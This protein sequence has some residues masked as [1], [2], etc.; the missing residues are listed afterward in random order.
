MVIR[1]GRAFVQSTVGP[2]W[3]PRHCAARAGEPG[4]PRARLNGAVISLALLIG[5]AALRTF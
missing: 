5:H 2:R 3:I 4:A 1:Y